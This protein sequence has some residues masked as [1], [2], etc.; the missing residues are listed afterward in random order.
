MLDIAGIDP[1]IFA[2]LSTRAVATSKAKEKNIPLDVI[3]KT[4]G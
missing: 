1:S 4:V 2:G 3:M